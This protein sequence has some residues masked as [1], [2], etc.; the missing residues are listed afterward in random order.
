MTVENVQERILDLLEQRG[1]S[2]YKLAKEAGVPG[3]TIYNIFKR[4]T[5][6]RLETID[7][8]CNT[9]GISVGDFFIFDTETSAEIMTEMD[10]ELIKI[11]RKLSGKLQERLLQYASGMK[12]AALDD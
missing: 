4:K 5:M 8:V 2:K 7:A 9:F 1:W 10:L 6:P 12:A 3:S 11:N